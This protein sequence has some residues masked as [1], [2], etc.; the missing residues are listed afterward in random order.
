MDIEKMTQLAFQCNPQAIAEDLLRK[1]KDRNFAREYIVQWHPI[2]LD[3]GSLAGGGDVKIPE[4]SLRCAKTMHNL[5]LG[6]ED[7][8][9]FRKILISLIIDFLLK[10]NPDLKIKSE[11]D[12]NGDCYIEATLS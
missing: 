6:D 11:C 1:L 2:I 8:A 4:Y 10:D 7:R 3:S 5:F 9:R 12:S